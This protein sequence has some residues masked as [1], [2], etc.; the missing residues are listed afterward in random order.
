[1]LTHSHIIV[2]TVPQLPAPRW[3]FPWKTQDIN[4]TSRAESGS[5][6]ADLSGAG[7]SKDVEGSAHNKVRNKARNRR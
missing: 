3:I 1:M 6:A 4:R 2:K 5:P 7:R